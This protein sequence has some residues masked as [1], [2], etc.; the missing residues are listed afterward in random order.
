MFHGVDEY[1]RERDRNRRRVALTTLVLHAGALSFLLF[2]AL[3][4]VRARLSKPIRKVVRFGYEGPERYVPLIQLEGSPGY[5]P[6]LEDIGHVAT[7]RTQ[8]GS[9]ARKPGPS[10]N[11]SGP[12]PT[13]SRL[14]G[15]GPDDSEQRARARARQASVPL[16][17][18]SDLVIESMIEPVYPE[19][20]HSRGV[21]GRVALMALVDTTGRI[22][23]VTVVGGTG[24]QAFE[25]AAMDAVWQAKFKPFRIS[26]EAREVY[27]LI[28]YRFRIY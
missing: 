19:D 1:F 2:L 24:Q 22:S 6:P 26:G 10:D 8:Q 9:Q 15:V 28:R 13:H 16:V 18:S 12:Q 14:P 4:A 23:E 21:E 11:P 7:Y 3:P 27:A 25:R 20:L 5:K 17:S